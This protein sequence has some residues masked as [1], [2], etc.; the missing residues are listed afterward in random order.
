MLK[1]IR[2]FVVAGFVSGTLLTTFR[3]QAQRNESKDL[4]IDAELPGGNII[5]ERIAGDTVWITQDLR[6][7][8]GNWFYWYF[9]VKGAAGRN[10]S[11]RFTHPWK[12]LP[13]MQTISAGGVAV[14]MDKGVTWDW[15]T[16]GTFSRNAFTFK[17]PEHADEVQFSM[18]MP[19]TQANLD[20]FLE[21]YKGNPRLEVNALT[22]TKGD[23][24]I[25]KLHIGNL[26]GKPKYKLLITARHHACEM[27]ASY[28]LEGMIEEFL[29]D[30]EVGK[31][32]ME[33]TEVMVVPFIDKDGVEN[34]D[35]GKNRR[36]RDHNRDYSGE[37]I[38]ESTRALR[39]FVPV[40]SGGQMTM[41]LDLHC[42]F[43][44]GAEHERI[45]FV[46]SSDSLIWKEEIRLSNILEKESSESRGLKFRTVDNLPFGTSWN[47]TANT[48][49]GDSFRQWAR[50]LKGIKIASTLEY[51]YSMASGDRVTQSNSRLFGKVVAKAI[52]R[53]LSGGEN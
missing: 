9:R 26:H 33:N 50:H 53:Y 3:S 13:V 34:G 40:W 37:S 23:R 43:I 17:F 15:S 45:H 12:Q 52:Y 25:E 24:L 1:K 51:P 31:W 8:E 4:Q 29:D 38:Y 28:V 39:S 18:G 48:S 2:F 30:G 46:G 32:I 11:F 7:T 44:A 41:A 16:G 35:Q 49:K 47:V 21:K 27:M 36:G 14:S 5:V 10:I 22:R 42:P 19:Y 6:E 20:K